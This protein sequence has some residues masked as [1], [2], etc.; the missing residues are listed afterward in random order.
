MWFFWA[1]HRDVSESVPI[2]LEMGSA[3]DHDLCEYTRNEFS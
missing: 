3:K 1:S 2:C